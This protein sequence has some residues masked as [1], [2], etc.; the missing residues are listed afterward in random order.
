MCDYPTLS[1]AQSND[2]SGRSAGQE[3]HFGSLCL[4]HRW[5]TRQGIERPGAQPFD[6]L[7]P[8]AYSG[9]CVITPARV[10]GGVSPA[11]V[12]GKQRPLNFREWVAGLEEWVFLGSVGVFAVFL[13]VRMVQVSLSE[14]SLDFRARHS[15]KRF[16]ERARLP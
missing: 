6:Y 9:V 16:Q 2:R 5:L 14:L 15:K 13:Y 3:L 11:R 4:T 10:F 7:L 12:D 8:A 1:R